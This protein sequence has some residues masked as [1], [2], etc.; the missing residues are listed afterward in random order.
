MYMAAASFVEGAFSGKKKNFLSRDH[1]PQVPD[2]HDF[3]IIW[4][5]IKGI[6]LY[7]LEIWGRR[8]GLDAVVLRWACVNVV[9]IKYWEFP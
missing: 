4:C 3:W 2:C 9:M 1:S 6:L 5:Q 8:V 7:I